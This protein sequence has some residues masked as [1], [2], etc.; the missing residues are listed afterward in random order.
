MLNRERT[1]T[2]IKA[3]WIAVVGNAI[4]A[5]LKI[6]TGMLAGSFALVGDGIDS[7]GDVATSMI[8]LFTARLIAKPPD[9]KFPYGYRKADAIASKAL[10][11]VIFFAGAQLAISSFQQLLHN[12]SLSIPDPRAIIVVIISIVAKLLLSGYLF[13]TGKKLES[14]MLLANGRN[15]KND[16]FISLSVLLGLFF[17]FILKMPVIDSI[18]AL[19]ISI[20]IMK[21]GFDI[22]IETNVELMDGVED[23]GIYKKIIETVATVDGAENPHRLRVRKIAN[24]YL[25]G[26]DIEVNP[27]LN[28]AQGHRIA[29]KVENSLKE[30]LGNVYDILVHVEPFGN[31]ENDEPFGISGK[32]I[33]P[34]S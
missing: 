6:A 27:T 14:P 34:K 25:I 15:M 5:I 20:Y 10:S 3:S 2:I 23:E 21:T 22:F 24:M 11:F 28:I 33:N 17:T 7:T 31:V 12:E 18:F 26:M 32:D 13:K 4:L 8:T 30:T 19:L 9:L 16:V 29:K 1:K